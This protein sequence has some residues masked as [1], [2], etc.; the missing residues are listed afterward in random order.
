MI[1]TDLAPIKTRNAKNRPIN[2]LGVVSLVVDI[3]GRAEVMNFKVVKRLAVP[4]ILGCDY[5]DKHAEAIRP[6][7]VIVELDDRTTAPILRRQLR[8]LVGTILLPEQKECIP[9]KRRSYN[10]IQVTTKTTLQPESH[11]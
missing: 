4:V 1:K 9:S 10:T 3:G 7:Q 6:R 11:N 2:T 5:Y 8:R